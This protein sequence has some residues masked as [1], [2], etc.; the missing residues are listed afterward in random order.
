M[1]LQNFASMMVERHNKPEIEAEAN[2]EVLMN[3]LTISRNPREKVLV[4]SSINSIRISVKIK[5]MDEVDTILVQKFMRFLMQR[6]EAFVILRRKPVKGY[7][8]SFLICNFHTEQMYK[9]KLVDF[10]VQF[11]EDVD[12]EV[13]SLKITLNARA[14]IAASEFLRCFM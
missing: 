4:E 9:H 13:S 7:D 2:K 12:K 5:Q 10:V 1:C 11:L 8:V 3:P 6:A 14:R